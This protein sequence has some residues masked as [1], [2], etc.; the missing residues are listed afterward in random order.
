MIIG[1]RFTGVE[2]VLAWVQ[3][4]GMVGISVEYRLAP[5]HPDPAPAD[6]AYAALVWVSEHAAELGIAPTASCSPAARPAA[7]IAAASP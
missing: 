5:E 1:D 3:E 7:G 4:H 2:E 6:D